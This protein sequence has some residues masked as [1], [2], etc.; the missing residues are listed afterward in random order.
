MKKDTICYLNEIREKATVRVVAHDGN[1][2][3]ARRL[4]DMGLVQG[5]EFQIIVPGGEHSPYLIVVD[6]TRLAIESDLAEKLRVMETVHSFGCKHKRRRR[7]RRK[8]RKK[9]NFPGLLRGSENN[10]I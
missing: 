2:E 8:M 5:M 4:S 7:E 10:G 1:G 6:E 9:R 3:T